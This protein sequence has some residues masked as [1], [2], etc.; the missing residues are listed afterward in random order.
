[1]DSFGKKV[2]EMKEASDN[3]ISFER[4]PLY[5]EA[6]QQIVAGDEDGAI[7]TLKRL[8]ERYPEE[9]ALQDLLVRLQLRSTFGGG[10]YIPVDHS[11]G[12]PVLRTL[13]LVLLAITT[14][15]VIGTAIVAIY[16][17]WWVPEAEAQQMEAQIKALWDDVGSLLG[18][19]D[20]SGA[21]DKLEKLAELTPEDQK[22]QEALREIDRRKLCTDRYADAVSARDRGDWQTAMELLYQIPQECENHGQA[23]ALLEELKEIDTV[24][25][26]W[27]EAQ[28]LLA[29]EDWQGAATILAWIRQ[30]DQ[31]FKTTQVEDLLFDCHRRLAQQ[32]LD[33]ARGDVESVRLAA[34]HLQEAL[35]LKPANQD[36]GHAY[37]L[38]VGYVAGFE[39]Y[40]RGDWASAVAR[41]EPLY[42][43]QPDYQSGVLRQ[44]LHDS[45]P[46]AA[47]QLVSEAS[48][49]VRLLTQ[50][51]DYFDRA[52]ALD[53][54]NEELLQE[55]TFA[56]EFLEGLEAYTGL[57]YDLAI[58]H[59]GPIHLVRPDYQNNALAE[60]LRQACMQSLAPD[61]QYCRP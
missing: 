43:M 4:H 58:S 34:S 57:D 60:Q 28:S 30:E 9:Q 41:W 46:R 8:I 2:V 37:S 5:K 14:C 49:S 53:P 6:M 16:N 61:E 36:L 48:G 29:A 22:I 55:R 33:Q 50:A 3:T 1:M 15:L 42:A 11:Q 18:K 35:R 20:L 26:A 38:A 56:V 23:L 21:R 7:A 17:N 47:R 31:D 52:L 25:T 13:V 12:A 59:W 40:D 51:V 45:Y 44:K 54:A 24:E 32:L 19:G 27:I 39:A 10:D